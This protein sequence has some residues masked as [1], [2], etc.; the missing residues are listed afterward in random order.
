MEQNKETLPKENMEDKIDFVK[1]DYT[2][3][4]LTF[5]LVGIL[6]VFL[7]GI[8]IIIINVNAESVKNDLNNEI[9][10]IIL[11]NSDQNNS[12]VLFNEKAKLKIFPLPHILINNIVG[13][14]LSQ[15]NYKLNFNIK[16][17]KLYISIKN[18]L[19]G[20]VVIH[21]IE[22]LD[23]DFN[24]SELSREE[25]NQTL[26]KILE[27]YLSKNNSVIFTSK[28][29]NVMVDF[30]Y[31]KREFSDINLDFILLKNKINVNGSIKS[32]K[33]H[34]NVDLKFNKN[35]NGI[36]DGNLKLSSL[37]FNG[38]IDING[39]TTKHQFSGTS[40]FHIDDFQIFSRTLFNQKSFLYKRVIDNS[41]LQFNSS[42]SFQNNIL[43]ISDIEVVGKNIN[44]NGL[45]K[46]N[47]N[48]N[49]K[50]EINFNISNINI[51]N[52]ITKNLSGSKQL[53]GEEIIIFGKGEINKIN[54]EKYQTILDKKFTINPIF[55][56]IKINEILLNGNKLLNSQIN[57]SYLTNRILNFTNVKSELPG[58]T[59]LTITEENKKDKLSI[60]GKN[61]EEFLGFLR[62]IE[63]IPNKEKNKEF[64][65][66]GD[67]IVKDDRLF[68][69]NSIFKLDNINFQN[70]VEIKFNNGINFIA[71]NAKTNNLNLNNF[72]KEDSNEEQ[73][74]NTL[75]NKI[76]FINSFGL[77]IYT[78]F[79]IDT[80]NYKDI[81]IPK[82]NLILRTGQGILS[83]EKIN[84]NNKVKGRIYFNIVNKNPVLD[85]NLEL[86]NLNYDNDINFSNLIFKLP[87]LDD[88]YGNIVLSG[89]NITLKKQSINHF[90]FNSKVSNGIIN[91]NTFN[92]EGFGGKCNISG[93]LNMQFSKKLNLTLNA[94]TANIKN[95]LEPLTNISN[96]EGLIGFSAVLYA[97]GQTVNLF[98]KS[99]ILKSQL[100]GSNI[101]VNK[102]GLTQLNT[103][104]FNIQVDTKLLNNIKP[105]ETLLNQNNQTLFESLAGTLQY[106]SQKGTFNIDISR[107]FIN[108]KI[109]GNFNFLKDGIDI[110]INANFIL[111][112]GTLKKT[113]PLTLL[114]KITGKTP[115]NINIIT[116]L[117]QIDDYIKS[118][119]DFINKKKR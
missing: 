57:F 49:Q 59:N 68:V 104:L 115:D 97:E 4:I 94:C 53:N 114:T 100:V 80:L 20:K 74:N 14:N 2:F 107:A 43:E 3:K 95:I 5:S 10:K 50:N 70:Q 117:K 47:F 118:I 119:K 30:I 31:S 60:T 84:I 37:V 67:L 106:I 15:N 73:L 82:C 28:R 88:F 8:I 79:Y 26:D 18:I 66:N 55:F 113:I 44:F 54:N 25:N 61:F 98:N 71:I 24:L 101:K 64:S 99:Y 19:I 108:G 23:S 40:K 87:S 92:E 58:N 45:M 46:F 111:L 27:E 22:V 90:D 102:Y 38:N 39:D 48:E 110:D 78:N 35:K 33:Q 116:N 109:L 103:D 86:N 1:T 36:F 32:N 21:K 63:Y 72:I 89:N 81:V 56:D 77:N 29:N 11:R 34:L 42:F 16:Q 17:A 41:N 65:F 105:Q 7:M 62:D 51:D 6:S 52:L 76:L 85:I 91:I 75:K 93:F 83:L 112:S 13:K 96:I 9:S 69:N 12:E